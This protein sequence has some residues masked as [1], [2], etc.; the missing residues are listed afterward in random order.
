MSINIVDL[1]KNYISPDLITRVSTSLGEGEDGISKALSGLI[2]SIL[3]GVVAKGTQS[4]ADAGQL[5]HEAKEA[6]NS[7]LLGNLSSFFG[8]A[9]L[10]SQ[11]TGWFNKIFDGQSNI[12]IDTISNFA[13]IKSSSSGSLISMVTPLI[14]GLLGKQATENNMDANGFSRFLN[15]QKS[16]I[17]S[18]LPSGLGS[19]ASMLGLGALGSTARETLENA[20]AA[21]TATYNYAE[22]QAEKAGGGMKW[23]LPLL[24]LAALAFLLW[25]LMGKGC[26][27]GEGTTGSDTVVT[28]PMDTAATLAPVTTTG[29]LDTATGNYIYDV[30]ANK[31]IKLADGTTLTVGENSTEARLYHMLNDAAFTVDTVNKSANWVVLDRVY[32]ETGKSVLTA[33]SAAQILNIASILKNFP[34]A[35]I[36]LGG[37]TDNTGDAAI[38]K[39]VSA[40]RAK[41]VSQEMIKAGADAKQVVEAEGYGP[42]FPVCEANDTPECKAQNRRVD[43]KVAVK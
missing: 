33:E 10:Q 36:K 2:P 20:E 5:L 28:A 27:K 41:I 3:G 19:L 32:F 9:D 34:K 25:W 1:V 22:Q 16:N 24:L 42:E 40:E 29:A 31:E 7:G 30:G 15:T 17:L 38:N 35:A 18:A 4:E 39:K 13:G 12:I 21:S 6:N 23:L 37:Y 14:M 8:N 11:G 26:N 43:L